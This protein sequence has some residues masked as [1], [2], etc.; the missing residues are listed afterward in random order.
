[1]NVPYTTNVELRQRKCLMKG[2]ARAML[3]ALAVSTL[4]AFLAPAM[5]ATNEAARSM[6]LWGQI[7]LLILSVVV[8]WILVAPLKFKDIGTIIMA[9]PKRPAPPMPECKPPKV[10]PH[11]DEVATDIFAAHMKG[12]LA[13]ARKKGRYGWWDDHVVTVA[14]LELMLR[15]A[16]GKGD[17]IDIANFCM[18]LHQRGVTQT[19]KAL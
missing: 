15:L 13:E 19:S 10:A 2:I 14:D 9:D 16:Y 6:P 3:V 8:V 18:M 17:V 11:L 1:M 7:V 4:A 5:A 12:R